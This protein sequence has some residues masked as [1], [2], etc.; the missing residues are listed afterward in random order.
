MKRDHKISIVI[1]LYLIFLYTL[2]FLGCAIMD[3]YTWL[4]AWK[5]LKILGIGLGVS[6]LIF[7]FGFLLHKWLDE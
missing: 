6:A 7:I 3:G 4:C 5:A 2:C 1:I